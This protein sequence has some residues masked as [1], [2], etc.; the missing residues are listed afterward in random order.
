MDYLELVKI[1]KQKQKKVTVTDD[2]ILA[3]LKEVEQ[4]IKN[5][6]HIPE[7]PVALNYTWCNMSVDLLLYQHE[8]NTTPNDVL[9]AFDPSDVSTIKVGDTSISLGDKYRNNA[10]SRT[11]QS[12][13]S[14]LDDIVLNYRAQ[15]NNFRRL[16]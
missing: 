4:A 5:Y 12:H 1:I 7:V 6:C 2:D 15:L 11:L 3:C 16:W 8:V 10:R 14:N 13:N 9:E